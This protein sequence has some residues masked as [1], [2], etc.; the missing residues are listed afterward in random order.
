MAVLLPWLDRRVPPDEVLLDA[1]T[2]R[3]AP[4]HPVPDRLLLIACGALAR[5]AERCIGAEGWW[6]VDLEALP[7]RYHVQPDRIAHAIRARA[8]VAV[9]RGYGGVAAL[10]GDCGSTGAIEAA[11][12]DEGV[13]LARLPHC[14]AM[15]DRR[16]ATAEPGE[17]G[18]FFLTDF[19][20]RHFEAMVWQPMRLARHPDLIELL[21]APY[22]RIV[23]LAQR[24]DP[25][26]DAAAVRVAVRLNLPLERRPA[27]P[28]RL[29]PVLMPLVQAARDTK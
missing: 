13:A 19:M 11:C 24:D 14:G 17:D 16:L 3:A 1:G 9:A 21:F 20:L 23:H 25:T 15:Y 8:R 5:D 26:L 4:P 22:D 29:V 12:R 18:S 28:D 2:M 7:A 10:F 6:H 27:P